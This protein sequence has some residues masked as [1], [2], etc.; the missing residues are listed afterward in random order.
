MTVTPRPAG[1]YGE[2]PRVAF[3]GEM[4]ANSEIAIRRFLERAEPASYRILGV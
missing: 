1:D 3:Q 4:G 2:L